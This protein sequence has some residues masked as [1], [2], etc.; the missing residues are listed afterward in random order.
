MDDL[1]AVVVHAL[2]N[3][4]LDGPV[5][6]VA[7][8]AATNAEFARALGTIL[9]RPTPFSIPAVVVRLMFGKMADETLLASARV[10]PARLLETGFE[11]RFAQLDGALRHLLGTASR[12]RWRHRRAV[13]ICPS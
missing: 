8:A 9:R 6:A 7:P 10:R 4:A 13:S 11:F 2:S 12:S 1:E 5:N 3:A